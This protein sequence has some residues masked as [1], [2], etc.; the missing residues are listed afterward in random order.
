MAWLLK[1]GPKPV[2][3]WE[4]KT[5]QGYH[6]KGKVL[7]MLA[8]GWAID[9]QTPVTIGGTTIGGQFVFVFKRRNPDYRP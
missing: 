7:A 3:E 8:E 2:T 1:T 9:S 5:V 6:G 4:Y